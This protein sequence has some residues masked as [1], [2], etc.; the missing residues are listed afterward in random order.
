MLP[1]E[2][3]ATTDSGHSPKV[4]NRAEALTLLDQVAA[5][6]RSAEP[7]NP[8]PFLLERG[9]DLAQRDFLGVLREV[10]AADALKTRDKG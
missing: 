6:L 2:A 4:T 10:L 7:S 1:N 5:Y 8:I 9:R 3:A